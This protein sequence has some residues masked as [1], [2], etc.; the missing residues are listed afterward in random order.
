MLSAEELISHALTALERAYAP[1]S[2]YHVGA[3]IETDRGAIVI[4]CNV[5]NLSYGATICAERTAVTS[6]IAGDLGEGIVQLAVSSVD[7]VPPCGVCLQVL[8]EFMD[9]DA[10]VHLSKGTE[11]VR[12]YRF[13]E[14]LPH[15]FESDAVKRT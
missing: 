12:S 15:A 9:G 11:L 2:G 4:G 10:L 13:R 8:Q 14:L 7:G 3:A 1:Y 5:E 6:M